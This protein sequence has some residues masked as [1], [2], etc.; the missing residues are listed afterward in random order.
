LYI[1]IIISELVNKKLLLA[2][3]EVSKM[4]NS[5]NT[6][7]ETYESKLE[8]YFSTQKF[9]ATGD[10]AGKK[11]FFCLGQYTRKVMGCMERQVAENGKEDKEQKKLTKY[12]TYNMSYR[13]FTN[14]AKLLDKYA[15]QINTKLLACGG[16]SR[17][18]LINA[19]FTSDKTK[20]PI[21]DA[22]TAFSLG[23]Y[24]VFK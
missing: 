1:G 21:I 9:F 3:Y 5:I 4:S 8:E 7:T 18:Y 6:K 13:N 15:L 19:E 14:L 12:A 20:L 22:N 10:S 17:R 2:K 24:Q 23:L 16:F 11:A